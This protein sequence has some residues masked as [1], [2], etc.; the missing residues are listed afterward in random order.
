ML[1]LLALGA[2]YD[3]GAYD[4]YMQNHQLTQY[5][6][7]LTKFKESRVIKL[8]NPNNKQAELIELAKFGLSW[9]SDNSPENKLQKP[10]KL[11]G[12]ILLRTKK[13]RN[14]KLKSAN[15]LTGIA[16]AR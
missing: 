2:F 3:S 11:L 6:F 14:Q 8:T 9:P 13:L 16:H 10:S 1:K 7:P 5:A 4:D 12:Y 15:R